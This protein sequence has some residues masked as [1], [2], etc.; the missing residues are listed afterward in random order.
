M[1]KNVAI[2]LFDGVEILDF[3]SP[4]EVFGMANE[5]NGNGL[6]NVFTVAQ[7]T[8]PIKTS[9]GLSVN[10]RFTFDY[11]PEVDILIIPGGNGSKYIIEN[12]ESMQWI[13]EAKSAAEKTIA[14]SSGAKILAHIGALDNIEYCTHSDTFNEIQKVAPLAIPQRYIR[15][16]KDNNIYSCISPVAG[17]EL[18]LAII[19]ELNGKNIAKDIAQHIESMQVA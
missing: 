2:V 9:N 17:L 11:A 18:S 7:H 8:E 6:Y 4:Y 3:T 10:P 16:T 5:L 13:A 14:I 1:K 15:Y 12:K 19:E